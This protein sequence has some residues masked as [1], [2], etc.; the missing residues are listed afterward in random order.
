LEDIDIMA[1]RRVALYFAWSRPAEIGA[2]FGVLE[3]RYPTLYE[4]RRALWPEFESLKQAPPFLQDI[5]G[6]LDH[7]VLHDF[8]RFAN[9]IKEVTGNEVPIIQRVGNQPPAKELDHDFLGN[10]DTLIVVSLDHFRTAQTATAGEIECVRDFLRREE[11]CVFVCPHHDIGAS[12]DLNAETVEFEHHQDRTIPGQ[13]RIGGF[14]RSL[15]AGLGFAVENR[16]GLNPK[17]E[18]DGSPSR[19]ILNFDLKDEDLLKGVTTFNL[20]PHLP[21]LDFAP[22]AGGHVDVLAQQLINPLAAPHPFFAAGNRTFQALLG[23]RSPGQWPG[24][25]YVGDATLWSAAFGGLT[26]L[27]TLWRNIANM[28]MRA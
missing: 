19:L 14:A 11:R 13:Q 26:S 28:P 10:Y 16:W 24:R 12:G 2:D 20:H 3:N 25:L 5:S 9:L 1:G 6:F 21:H 7:V 18:M 23:L 22:A 17:A 8:Q 4:F 15:L 27:T